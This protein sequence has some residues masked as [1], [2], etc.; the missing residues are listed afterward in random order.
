ML[1]GE[2]LEPD[3]AQLGCEPVEG[4]AVFI[5][6]QQEIACPGERRKV[7]GPH[8]RVGWMIARKIQ[9]ELSCSTDLVIQ[10]A[11]ARL[12]EQLPRRDHVDA[13]VL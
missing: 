1:E 13:R 12:S 9:Q 11:D 4:V 2:H 6:V 3:H 5:G 8:D 7:R 10:R